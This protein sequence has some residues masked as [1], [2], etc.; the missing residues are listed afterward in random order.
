MHLTGDGALTPEA[1]IARW[2][3]LSD[4]IEPAIFAESARWGDHYRDSRLDPEGE[5]YTYDDHWLPE[6]ERLLERYFPD[7]RDIALQQFIEAELHVTP[8][9][10]QE[11]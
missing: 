1:L 8:E 4:A 5:L 2:T 11:P 6:H 7:R 9:P 3:A 10:P